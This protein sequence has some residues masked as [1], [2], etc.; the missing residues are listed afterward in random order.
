[1]RERTRLGGQID[2]VKALMDQYKE[3]LEFS[4]LGEAEGDDA[5]IEEARQ[6][7]TVAQEKARRA[8]LEQLSQEEAHA[9]TTGLL[10]TMKRLFA[11]LTGP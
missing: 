2:A 3:G 6:T 1:M 8:E 5:L 10:Q 11:A 9:Q 7:L 4:E